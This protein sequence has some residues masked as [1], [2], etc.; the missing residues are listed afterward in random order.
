MRVLEEQLLP[1]LRHLRCLGQA[2]KL[3]VQLFLRFG[4][5]WVERDALDRTD[6]LALRCVEVAD[7]LRA[8]V[9]VEIGRASCRERV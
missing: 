2:Q 1:G 9:R 8:A 3:R 4:P 7:A 6:L 5:V